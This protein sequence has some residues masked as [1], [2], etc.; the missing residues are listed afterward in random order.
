LWV[1]GLFAC[2]SPVPQSADTTAP[3]AR[4]QAYRANNVGVALLEQLDYAGATAA[5]QGAL[6]ADPTLG[7]ARLNLALA[8]LYEQDFAGAEREATEAAA[9]LPS[10]PQPPYVL[11]LVARAQTRNDEARGFFERV[12]AID[13]ADVG[14]NVNLA[15]IALE[16]RRYDDAIAALRPVVAVEPFHVTASYVLGLALTRAGRTEEGQPLLERAQTLRKT[17]Y[18]VTF[19]TGYL[20][21][22]RYAE[23][24][25][26]T[27]AE[28]E[29]VDQGPS[30]AQFSDTRIGASAAVPDV[31]PAEGR[32]FAARALDARGAQSLATSLDGGVTLLDVDGDG[33][34]DIFR[35]GG[36]GVR[37]LRNDGGA[38]TEST[39]GSG[40]ESAAEPGTPVGAVAAD[41]DNDGAVDLYV[42]RYG[43]GSL[44]RNDGKGRFSDV[45]RQARL[46][47]LPFLPGA[48]AFADVDHDGD[49][50]LLVAGLADVEATRRAAGTAERLFPAEFSPA[51]VQLLRNN[52][53]GTFTD[54]TRDARLDLR[55]H[56][57]AIVP[58][59]FDNRRDI[60]LLFV[61]ADGPPALYAN[62]RDGTFKDVTAEVGLAAMGVGGTGFATAATGDVNKDDWPDLFLAGESGGVLALSDGRGRFTVSPLPSGGQRARAAQLVDYDADGLLDLVMWTADGVRA[63]RNLGREWRDVT[64]E[65]FAVSDP[66]DAAR[67]ASPRALAVADLDGDGYSD[68]VTAHGGTLSLWRN[69]GDD[70]HRTIRV[71]LQ[72]RVSNRLGIGTKIQARAG[73]LSARAETSSASPAV[74]PSD[75]VFG[76]G[77]RAGADA[78]RLLW[79]SG[80]LQA[81]IAGRAEGAAPSTLPSPFRVE[82]LDR[83]PSSCPFL[84][85]WNG[86]RFEFVTDFLGGG[87]MGAWQAP[88]VFNRPDPVEYV[89]IRGDQL[90]PREGRFDLRVTNELEETLFLD[91]FQL[92]AVAHPADVEV[93]PN[94]GMT[95]PAKPHRLHVVRDLRPPLG[96]V[97][98][99]GVDV[100][101][102]LAR[103]DR[104]YAD[105]F[106]LERVR[107]YAAPHHL[108][109]DL[110]PRTGGPVLLLTGWTDYAF[111]SDTLAARQAGLVFDVPTLAVQ[112]GS[113]AWRP[114]PVDVGFPVG[115]PQ[116]I[117][118]DLT[119][120]LRPGERLLRLA[121]T[122]RIYWDQVVVGTAAPVTPVES[123][124]LSPH[125]AVL[126]ERGF[127]AEVRPDG[128]NPPG[129]DYARTTHESPWKAFSGAF[130]RLG[131]V[132]PLVAASDDHFVIAKT[133]DEIAL[134]F[135]AGRLP[136]LP[137]GWT[138][139]FLLRGD[140]FSKEMDINSATPYTVEPLPFH[141]MSAYPYPETER[142][143]DTAAHRAYREQYNT[144]RVV[145]PLPPFRG[146]R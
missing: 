138:R 73:S 137:A 127:S 114:L 32:R 141:G 82:E 29:L 136:A 52:R 38:W 130:T 112:T 21:Q 83:K 65:A 125:T 90:K 128:Q 74:G 71:H 8:R 4:E 49:V 15:Q 31:Q 57:V 86:E 26:S 79:P 39:A 30:R 129:Y 69:R 96:V 40:L 98:E 42:F 139:T 27:G 41:I 105:G 19:G 28:P 51:P 132:A 118:V 35:V 107:G 70:R 88:G 43:S 61:R 123:V 102:R 36:E 134:S 18:A 9:R 133:G 113:G 77:T 23:A 11:G 37:L 80:I 63:L 126:R 81:E 62:Q 16:E 99:R 87:E 120:L 46:P 55:G 85:T 76:L 84:Y 78:V 2:G 48:A 145:R 142:Y 92:V 146:T 24:I 108:T 25:A 93:F 60:D 66:A 14:A 109:I 97:D 54:V 124:I 95:E 12:R 104:T 56:I 1:A 117:A 119:G 53:D 68:A 94:E 116:S 106:A 33:D 91:Q 7:M 115:R 6:E 135:D 100:A 47:R 67:V 101:D 59:D 75:V 121:T 111:S 10:A 5:F 45:T 44:Y 34:L 20:E 17:G 103:I 64:G 140:G 3:A 110:G 50:D 72:G 143:P 144:R 13:P 58:T 122:M 131:D 89:R 22:G